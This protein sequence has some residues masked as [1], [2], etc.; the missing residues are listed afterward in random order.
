MN[1]KRMFLL[2][3]KINDLKALV[4]LTNK[5]SCSVYA[6]RNEYVVDAK[7]L[8]GLMSLNLSKPICLISDED[9]PEEIYNELKNFSVE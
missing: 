3:D 1:K 2:V 7:S 5:L 8:L 6:Q 4:D 9:I